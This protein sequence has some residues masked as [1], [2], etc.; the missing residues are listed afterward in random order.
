LITKHNGDAEP[1]DYTAFSSLRRI[2]KTLQQRGFLFV[3]RE[4]KKGADVVRNLVIAIVWK[5]TGREIHL[6][7][8]P[9]W[10]RCMLSLED[11][12]L[13]CVANVT[14]SRNPHFTCLQRFTTGSYHTTWIHILIPSSF[15]I[16]RL[17]SR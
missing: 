15:E 8:S 9:V 2:N 12:S 6:L 4:I 14:W 1:Y 10:G 7:S 16:S 3:K 11:W 17:R 13:I 5:R